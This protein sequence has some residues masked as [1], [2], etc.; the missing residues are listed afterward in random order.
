MGRRFESLS[1]QII[2]AALAV[3]IDLGPGFIE[4]IYENAM[5]IALAKRG[6]PFESQRV[7]QIS[8]QGHLVGRHRLDLVVAEEIVVE[9]KAVALLDR[10]HVAQLRSYLRA[11]RLNVGL[12]LNF[13]AS[14]LVVKR[15]VL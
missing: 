2:E 9:L 15:V 10:T 14:R 11:T 3:H 1:G 5:V 13:N 8:F 4:S 6:I 7:D 12:L